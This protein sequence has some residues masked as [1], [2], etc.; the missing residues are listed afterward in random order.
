MSLI[1]FHDTTVG[2]YYYDWTNK[3]ARTDRANGRVDRYC[4]TVKWGNHACTQ[5]VVDNTRYMIYPDSNYCC[6]CC[7]AEQGC[8][9]VKPNWL[10][11]ATFSKVV[12]GKT[13]KNN[14]WIIKGAQSNYYYETVSTGIPERF[15]QDPDDD[16]TW[17]ATTYKETITDP[18]VFDLP[19]ICVGA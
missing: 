10:E 17:D 19:K 16:M 15:F 14:E 13:E 11:T 4:G 1:L 3:R 8:G 6:N 7:S 18:S 12:D 9:I 2:T 5:L